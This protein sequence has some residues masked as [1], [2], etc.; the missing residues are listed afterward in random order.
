MQRPDQQKKRRIEEAAAELFAARAYHEVKLDDVAARARIGKGTIY[1]YFASKEDLY[2]SLIHAGLGESVARL[3]ARLAGATETARE[4]LRTIVGE[5]VD[6]A[7][8]HPQ[9]FELMRQVGSPAA[10]DPRCRENL[11]AL[12][13]LIETTIRRGIRAG[14]M[15]DT[16]PE[17]T[18]V[19]V[20]GL[21]RSILLYGPPSVAQAKVRRH[22]ATLVER[23][24]TATAAAPKGGA[25][26]RE[27]RSA[28]QPSRARRRGH[29]A[30]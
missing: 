2:F 9:L 18:A 20:P 30:R 29:A 1:I 5:L 21:V 7:Y 25:G 14:E 23:A 10:H 22:I 11:D 6:F 16:H 3:Q 28:L 15:V 17:L 8:R 13:R 12:T 4:S 27:R 19:C 26:V 24:L